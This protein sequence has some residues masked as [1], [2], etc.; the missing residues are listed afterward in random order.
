MYRKPR[1]SHGYISI[2]F[3]GNLYKFE[4]WVNFVVH[5]S[6]QFRQC[7]IIVMRGLVYS[8]NTH[9][10]AYAPG[11]NARNTFLLCRLTEKVTCALQVYC[12]AMGSNMLNIN[13]NR[14]RLWINGRLRALERMSPQ[15]A[16]VYIC[17][18]PHSR[19]H[20]GTPKHARRHTRK[21][22]PGHADTRIHG[23]TRTDT[24]RHGQ[25]RTDT[26]RHGHTRTDTDTRTRARAS[27]ALST[28]SRREKLT[29]CQL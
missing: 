15:H 23:Q 11:T 19:A 29:I 26:D 16:T 28:K 27:P 4:S 6:D 17:I 10:V 8:G 7:S 1:R 13:D 20:V 3:I 14:E 22:E 5:Y 12:G 9:R 2:I 24:D 25:T 18:R 21:N